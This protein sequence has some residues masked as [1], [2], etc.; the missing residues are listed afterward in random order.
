VFRLLRWV[1]ASPKFEDKKIVLKFFR[2]EMELHKIDTW[3]PMQILTSLLS[4][5]SLW[6]DESSRDV[7]SSS[8]PLSMSAARSA[9]NAIIKV[10]ADCDRLATDLINH[11]CA[12]VTLF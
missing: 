8:V 1:K 7:D 5:S 10:F 12:Q 9:G 4:G 2:A 3:L 11:F 6:L